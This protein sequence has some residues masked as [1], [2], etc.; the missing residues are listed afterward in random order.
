MQAFPQSLDPTFTRLVCGKSFGS[1]SFEQ[2]RLLRRLIF[3]RQYTLLRDFLIGEISIDNASRSG[4]LANMKM[5]EF[6]KMKT[7]GDGSVIL[8]KDHKTMAS[9]GPARIVLSQ[10]MIKPLLFLIHRVFNT[11]SGRKY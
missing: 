3:Q 1:S 8:V 9:H 5:G 2:E 4:A 7:E 6:K 11:F 10:R